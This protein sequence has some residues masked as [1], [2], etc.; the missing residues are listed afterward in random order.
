MLRHMAR[1]YNPVPLRITNDDR[2]VAGTVD[3]QL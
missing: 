2:G 1:A 3:H